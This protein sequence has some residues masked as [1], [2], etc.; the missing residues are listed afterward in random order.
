MFTTL[1]YEQKIFLSLES[2][3]AKVT[4]IKHVMANKKTKQIEIELYKKQKPNSLIAQGLPGIICDKDTILL[5]KEQLAYAI[6]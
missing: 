2:E 6:L 1:E 4:Y 3:L 5:P